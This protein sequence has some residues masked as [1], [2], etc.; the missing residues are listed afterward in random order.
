MA[1][2]SVSG[3]QA[4]TSGAW[5]QLQLQQAR[6]DANRA[7]QQAAALQARAASA[8]TVAD[9]A[10][11]NARSLQVQSRQAQGDAAQARLNLASRDAVGEVQSQLSN[12]RTQIADVLQSDTLSS[13]LAPVINSSGQETGTLVNV[14]A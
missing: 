2:G 8:Q 6:Q 13:T 10:Q 9:R 1:V 14:T 4:A 5:A 12:L 7:E 11:E 3:T